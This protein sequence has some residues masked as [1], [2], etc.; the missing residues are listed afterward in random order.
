VIPDRGQLLVHA[1][2]HFAW[3]HMMGRG[4]WR[5][6]QD[7]GVLMRSREDWDNALFWARRWKG[8]SCCYW[9]LKLA[10]ILS[11]V[12][13]PADVLAAL[14]PPNP[15]LLEEMLTA[16]FL[17]QVLPWDGNSCPSV[18]AHDLLWKLAIRPAW[19]RHSRGMP[20]RDNEK[21]IVT[22]AAAADSESD[23]GVRR[24]AFAATRSI[25]YFARLLTDSFESAQSGPE[26]AL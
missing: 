1:C 2:L 7:V 13:V 10:G 21:W 19:S 16:H 26:R 18:R 12:E 5:T 24:M 11:R 20:E 9:T 3:S 8:N 6:I 25:R 14:R 22:E 15:R 17:S 4:A 23:R